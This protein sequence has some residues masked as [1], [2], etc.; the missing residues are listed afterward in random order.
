MRRTVSASTGSGTSRV[1][2]RGP[3]QFGG[4]GFFCFGGGGRKIDEIEL[5]HAD[6]AVV[7][8]LERFQK[9]GQESAVDK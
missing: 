2:V 8:I 9:V 6:A 7:P 1:L 4:P 5:E 3:N